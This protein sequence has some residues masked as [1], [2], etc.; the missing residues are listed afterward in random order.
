MSAGVLG[1]VRVGGVVE[2]ELLVNGIGMEESE[3]VGVEVM[4]EVVA[5]VIILELCAKRKMNNC[6]RGTE[7]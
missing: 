3:I 4:A 6:G 1:E 7:M 2:G 5:D